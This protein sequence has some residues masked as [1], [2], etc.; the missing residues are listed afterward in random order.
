M[1]EVEKENDGR[2]KSSMI[3]YNTICKCHNVL[4]PNT[5]IKKILEKGKKKE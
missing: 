4:L 2:V 3:Y 5:T 1:G